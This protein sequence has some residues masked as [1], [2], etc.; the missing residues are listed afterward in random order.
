[1]VIARGVEQLESADD[2]A[3]EERNVEIVKND[4]EG[5]EDLTLKPT[6]RSL[7]QLSHM[8]QRKEM[9]KKKCK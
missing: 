1:M 2:A 4:G 7:M 5:E 6:N 9:C 3:E 8:S